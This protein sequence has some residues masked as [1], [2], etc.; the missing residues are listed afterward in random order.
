MSCG[1]QLFDSERRAR[2]P[3]AS[4]HLQTILWHPSAVAVLRSKLQPPEKALLSPVKGS[5]HRWGDGPSPLAPL[6][7]SLDSPWSGVILT[8]LGGISES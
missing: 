8:P 3:A 2:F 7:H 1:V 5:K 4:R 6:A